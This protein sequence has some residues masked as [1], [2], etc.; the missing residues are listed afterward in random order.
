MRRGVRAARVFQD[1]GDG[2]I[3][4]GGIDAYKR[5]SFIREAK[6]GSEDDRAAEAGGDAD[7]GLFGQTASTRVTRGIAQLPANSVMPQRAKLS[8]N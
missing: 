3:S 5:D 7:L 2:T 1:N 6:Q 8:I 4:F